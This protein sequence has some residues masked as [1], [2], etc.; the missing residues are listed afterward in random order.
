MLG[1]LDFSSCLPAT[2]FTIKPKPKTIARIAT[3]TSSVVGSGFR[4]VGEVV[5]VGDGVGVGEGDV[6]SGGSTLMLSMLKCIIK[7]LRPAR[8]VLE[9]SILSSVALPLGTVIVRCSYGT[10]I[11][12]DSALPSWIVNMNGAAMLTRSSKRAVFLVAVSLGERTI[13]TTP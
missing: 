8:I 11:V 5:G 10:V 1:F 6:D 2:K 13:H 3:A 4:S 9:I 7:G 12:L